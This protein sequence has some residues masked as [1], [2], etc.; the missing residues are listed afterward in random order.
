MENPAL[1]LPT[2]G[3]RGRAIMEPS[4]LPGAA[5]TSYGASSVM[6]AHGFPMVIELLRRL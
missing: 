3:Q 2:V 6:I 4:H 5:G 1:T